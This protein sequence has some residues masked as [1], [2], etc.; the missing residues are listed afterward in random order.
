MKLFSVSSPLN[1]RAYYLYKQLRMQSFSATPDPTRF[2]RKRSVSPSLYSRISPLGDPNLSMAPVLDQWVGEGNSVNK[3][4]ILRIIK[5]LMA[6]RR[7]KHALEVSLW[8]TNKGRIPVAPVDVAMRLKSIFKLF[9][10]EG[11]EDYLKKVPE[12]LKAPSVYLALLNCYTVAKSVAKSEAVMQKARDSGYATL[13]IWYNLMMN[14][15]SKLGH[16][17]KVE[18]V[19]NEMESKNIPCDQFTHSVCLSTCASASDAVGMDKIVAIMESD[20]YGTVHW[21]TYVI[22][23]EGY[24]KMGLVDKAL[25]ILDKLEGLLITSNESS[26]ILVLLF[27]LYAEAGKRDELNR[28]WDVCKQKGKMGNKVYS[29]M[30]RSLLKFGDVEGMEKIYEEWESRGSHFD[31]RVPNFLI[32]AYCRDGNLEEA[33]AFIA[34]E[35]SKG[36]NPTVATWCHLAGGY[37][38]KNRVTDSVEALKK[39]ISVIPC[40]FISQKN[41]LTTCLEYLESGNCMEKAEE[42]I[43]SVRVRGILSEASFDHEL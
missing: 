15:H 14:L 16:V 43:N 9:G 20:K 28:I 23:A 11:V 33:E 26:V 30:L 29:S 34:R 36:G 1:P 24:L 17:E 3:S 22:A 42:L 37:L 7:F 12:H 21:R 13:P 41:S 31:F 27:R 25:P 18:D 19:L 2:S 38:K 39:A 32:D 40:K 5:E 10:L 4:E 8:M 6:Y 35:I